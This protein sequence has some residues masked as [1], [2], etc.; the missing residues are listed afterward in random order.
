LTAR[1]TSG[2]TNVAP[3]HFSR[4]ASPPRDRAE[5]ACA[6]LMWIAHRDFET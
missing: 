1:T 6:S 3:V 5:V 2:D 4:A